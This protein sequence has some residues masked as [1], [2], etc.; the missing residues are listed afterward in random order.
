MA[1][2]RAIPC[3]RTPSID[4][5]I[6]AIVPELEMTTLPRG[7]IDC[8]I[9]GFQ[10]I[11]AVADLG[12]YWR[13]YP[14]LRGTDELN[15]RVT[16]YPPGAPALPSRLATFPASL[17]RI[18]HCCNAMASTRSARDSRLHRGVSGTALALRGCCPFLRRI[19]RLGR[20]N[21]STAMC[22]CE[23]PSRYRPRILSFPVKA[24]TPWT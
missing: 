23:P 12:D 18:L 1:R 11:D 19:E 16:S 24:V 5:Q 7:S 9:S 14:T 8:D 15:L 4:T 13:E 3:Q 6:E 21:G 2:Q 17:V 22:D 20:A 10:H